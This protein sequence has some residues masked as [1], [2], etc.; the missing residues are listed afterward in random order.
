MMVPSL[1]FP[2]VIRRRYEKT[3]A[4]STAHSPRVHTVIG[5]KL[6]HP[7]LQHRQWHRPERQNRIV[8]VPLIKS[9]AQLF[10]RLATVPADLQ[11]AKLVGQRLP[12]PC[13]VALDLGP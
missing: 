8:K 6:R 4:V 12:G 7:L 3:E 5:D 9:G 1:V 13:D 10:L 2:P 11:L